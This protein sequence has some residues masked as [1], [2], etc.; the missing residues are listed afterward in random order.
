MFCCELKKRVHCILF[1]FAIYAASKRFLEN[2]IKVKGV[3]FSHQGAVGPCVHCSPSVAKSFNAFQKVHSKQMFLQRLVIDVGKCRFILRKP[4][5]SKINE[6]LLP[7]FP[8]HQ[9][10]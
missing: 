1:L 5:Q 2:Y 4:K 8:C 6:S 9:Q 10:L 7:K 3:V